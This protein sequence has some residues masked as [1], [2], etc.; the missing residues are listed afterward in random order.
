M[1]GFAYIKQLPGVDVVLNKEQGGCRDAQ[2]GDAH[3]K[4][5]PHCSIVLG[6]GWT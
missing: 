5:P 4:G 3:T 2:G 6:R 1:Q